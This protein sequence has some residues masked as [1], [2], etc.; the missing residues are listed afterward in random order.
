MSENHTIVLDERQRQA[1][2]LALAHLAVE[3]PGWDYML[4]QIALLMDNRLPGDRPQMFEDFKRFHDPRKFHLPADHPP[5]E[6]TAKY[7]ITN[8]GA[9][10]GCKTCGR[11]S[12]NLNDVRE[13]YCG[14]CHKFHNQASP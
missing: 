4:T 12:F 6:E 9:S 5:S 8:D 3:R 11:V 13:K 7:I 10:I 14:F 2:L 1:V